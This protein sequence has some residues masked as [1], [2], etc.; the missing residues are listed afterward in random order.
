MSE[1]ISRIEN[2][3]LIIEKRRTRM[4]DKDI[5]EIDLSEI[6]LGETYKSKI[7]YHNQTLNNK[8]IFF[9]DN[10]DGELDGYSLIVYTED[11]QVFYIVGSKVKIYQSLINVKTKVL[12]LKLNSRIFKISGIGYIV[13][14]CKL[15][16][17]DVEIF[18]SDNIRKKVK[19]KEYKRILSRTEM[20]K[21]KCFF[22]S[23]VNLEDIEK[24]ETQIL[25]HI[26]IIVKINDTEVPYRVLMKSKRIKKTREYYTPMKSVFRN[27]FAY[28]ARRTILGALVLIKR[29]KEDYEKT[30]RYK[31]LE[32]KFTSF[33]LCTIGKISKKLSSK[34]VNLYYEKFAQKSEEGAF[35]LFK[36]IRDESKKS[37]NYFIIDKNSE[38]YE[39]ISDER[40]V[41]KKYSL[42]YYM[43]LYK[44][45][46]CIATET[47]MHLNV[48]RGNNLFIRKILGEINFVF[49]QHGIIYMKSL[50]KNSPY[51]A[52]K[53]GAPDYIIV[54]SEKEKDVTTDM[55]KI[56]ENRI[57]KT[58]LGMLAKVEYNHINQ[59][60]EDNVAIMLTWKP[61]E[62]HLFEDFEKSTYYQY[63]VE[64]Y[65]ILKKY[66][67]KKNIII[68][69][70]P[71]VKELL[72]NTSMK[73][74]IW[75]GHIADMLVK[76]KLLITDYSSVC[77]NSFYQGAGVV[78]YQPDLEIYEAEN[79]QLIPSD[80][81]YIGRRAFNTKEFEEIIKDI[82][83][84]KKIDL[85][86][87]KKPEYGDIYKTINEFNDGKN[88]DRIYEE[89][90]IRKMV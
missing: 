12:T 73:D 24:D 68:L 61:Y 63:T 88:L 83:K 49:L 16:I 7:T 23:K 47:P 46:N 76:S 52:G 48:I 66:I 14:K 54:S 34:P 4:T 36:K 21:R 6:K 79:G 64:V 71:K 2:Q 65:N 30:L 75:S 86:K 11:S 82:I 38:D 15:K 78:F 70:H 80:N 13:N 69:P 84:D 20:I 90:K 87:A 51:T 3:K 29:P 43:L 56:D 39:K 9:L 17:D 55:L 40:N 1:I 18:F 31:L 74:S 5:E 67:D 45:S 33:V 72:C 26:K 41:V 42:K 19:L 81:E 59:D 37:K 10:L 28:N 8:I 32:N 22:K 27:D 35:D 77:Y 58:G 62:E 57:L 89:L 44:A 50:T 53:E 25:N 60:S 85:S